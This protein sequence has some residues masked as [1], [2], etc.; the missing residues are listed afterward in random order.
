MSHPLSRDAKRT[1]CPRRPMASDNWSSRTTTVARIKSPHKST[2]SISAGF[3]AL[4][5]S[6]CIES[7]HRTMS[8]FSP[9]S[10][11]T[12]FLM[13]DPRTPTQAPT[14]STFVSIELTATL[15]R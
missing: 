12:I 14:Q 4:G 2:S 6:T 7:F 5:I 3:S 8:I 11:S 13:R 10:S 1:F 15:V 9:P